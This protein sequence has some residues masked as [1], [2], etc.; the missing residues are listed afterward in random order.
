MPIPNPKP[1]VLLP[2]RLEIR[3]LQKT[4]DEEGKVHIARYSYDDKLDTSG[5]VIFGFRN[6]QT[7]KD[8]FPPSNKEIWIRWYPDD[9]QV[10][11][12]VSKITKA[13]KDAYTRYQQRK[14]ETDIEAVW[15]EFINEVGVRRARFLVDV[16]GV[17]PDF[18]TDDNYKKQD[19]KPDE[20]LYQFLAAG[21]KLKAFPQ[22]VKLYTIHE[23][24]GTLKRDVKFLD[25]GKEIPEDIVISS[26]DIPASRWTVDFEEAVAKGMGVKITDPDKCKQVEEAKWLIALGYKDDEGNILE[27][28]FRRNK[29]L[30]RLNILTRDTPTNNTEDIKTEFIANESGTEREREV[31]DAPGQEIAA[32]Y[33]TY[34][35]LLAATL[36]LDEKVFRGI[37]N[38]S[39][40]DNEAARVMRGLLFDPCT[41][42]YRDHFDRYFK[43]DAT[44][45]TWSLIRDYFASHVWGG[46]LLP[47]I[48]IGHNPYGILPVTNV[49]TWKSS[50]SRSEEKDCE[51]IIARICRFFNGIY[52][53]LAQSCPHIDPS[54][55]GDDVFDTLIQILQLH[56][57]SHRIDVQ[58]P[59]FE[60]DPQLLTCPLIANTENSQDP[61]DKVKKYLE[62]VKK[63]LD[64][65][66][67]DPEEWHIPDAEDIKTPLLKR[68]LQYYAVDIKTLK[69]P[70]RPVSDMIANI[71]NAIELIQTD[72]VSIEDLE[73]ALIEVFDSLSY[74]LDA[75]ITSLSCLRLH[76]MNESRTHSVQLPKNPSPSLLKKIQD[77]IKYLRLEDKCSYDK[78]NRILT[79]TGIM[80]KHQKD[81]FVAV[82]PEKY[83]ALIDELFKKSRDVSPGIGVY[84]WLEKP[85]ADGGKRSEGYFQ[86]PSLNQA[87]TGAILRSAALSD[88]SNDNGLF[89]INLSSERVKK[90]TWFTHGLQ[91]GYTPAELLGYQVERKLHDKKLDKY[92]LDLRRH[93]SLTGQDSNE[94]IKNSRVIDGEKFVAGGKEGFISG[95][96]R[97]PID[98]IRSEVRQIQDAVVDLHTAETLYQAIQGNAV[99]TAAWLDVAEG[100]N[101]PPTPEVMKTP[102]TGHPQIQRVLYPL[103]VQVD[104]INMSAIENPRTIAE[105]AIVELC[106]AH[107]KGFDEELFDAEVILREP[108]GVAQHTVPVS[109][110]KNLKMDPV[111]LVVGGKEELEKLTRMYI[112]KTLLSEKDDW[113]VLKSIFQDDNILNTLLEKG[114]VV[115]HK[116]Q[117]DSVYFDDSIINE[118]RLQERLNKADLSD[119]EKGKV[120]TVWQET[121]DWKFLGRDFLSSPTVLELSNRTFL[122]FNYKKDLVSLL[123]KAKRLR[124]FLKSVEPLQPE[125]LTD[126]YEKIVKSKAQGYLILQK[127]A[128]ALLESLHKIRGDV[129]SLESIPDLQDFFERAQDLVHRISKFGLV[130]TISFVPCINSEEDQNRIFQ[131]IKSFLA[132]KLIGFVDALNGIEKIE[133]NVNGETIVIKIIVE[134]DNI[135]FFK[136]VSGNNWEE[137]H[138][139]GIQTAAIDKCVLDAINGIESVKINLNGEAITI[140][141]REENGEIRFLK[142]RGGNNGD[143]IDDLGIQTAAIDK[144][145]EKRVS[146]LKKGT[147]GEAMPLFPPFKQDEPLTINKQIE[148]QDNVD[149]EV[150]TLEE[151]F[152]PYSKVRKNIATMMEITKNDSASED[153]LLSFSKIG[154]QKSKE[155]ALLKAAESKGIPFEDL[156]VDDVL[157]AEWPQ[158][159]ID[160]HFIVPEDGLVIEKDRFI[161]GFKVD[162]WTEFIPNPKQT[163]SLAFQYETP[164][165]EAPHAFLL[166]VPPSI[167]SFAWSDDE[168]AE[169][170]SDTID[171]MRI[172]AVPCE[173]IAGSELG[174][175]LP[176]LLFS[177]LPQ[178]KSLFPSEPIDLFDGII[179]G[180]FFY[181]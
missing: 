72:K 102:R 54:D 36:G 157:P 21:A 76:E 46:G 108:E 82:L 41:L 171:L 93:Y 53:K 40:I 159:N 128:K 78:R 83:K 147:A 31:Y 43:I 116:E 112:W 63:Y 77:I 13:E 70:D 7:A 47:T 50:A 100:K 180:G 32:D 146:F 174:N 119:S 103:P 52:M 26:N 23:D 164:Q 15:S 167:N 155:E 88:G 28:L 4:T 177:S 19:E 75:W 109:P 178:N 160:F 34:G 60:R 81:K 90:A 85:C 122:K 124:L 1:I 80:K 69:E 6:K 129:E 42:T 25:K 71:N 170:I 62:D 35:D 79:F 66:L 61:L 166:A 144:C 154:I 163:T 91:K 48:Q 12:R 86:A 145:I 37:Q 156:S 117:E 94:A 113:L 125:D 115:T 130:N 107:L 121:Q 51:E 149:Y 151:K 3:H 131:R 99:R 55:E 64:N 29:A 11:P 97:S 98:Q 126:S 44:D 169:I 10:F 150:F 5:D 18:D 38:A 104:E 2:L 162:E 14:G 132:K 65:G 96:D 165:A 22:R 33:L 175:F 8:V 138:D 17:D 57:V 173:A 134:N 110:K 148:T 142:H 9:C 181:K 127:R 27:E 161:V 176:S 118:E 179:K 120:L 133:L 68:I 141:I 105:P 16:D 135:R 114:I 143:G 123:E 153:N 74:R 89:H 39:R 73:N 136:E 56:P 67:G 84:G 87:I 59:G 58:L 24:R 95:E 139:S 45:Q 106:E 30:G 168:L 111:D 140:E 49:H 172:R 152:D 20:A 101:I 92:L 137:M 158:S